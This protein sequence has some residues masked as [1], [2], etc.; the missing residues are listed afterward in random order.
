MGGI[1]LIVL[2]YVMLILFVVLIAVDS[3]YFYILNKAVLNYKDK[4]K[5]KCQ[6]PGYNIYM[7][8]KWKKEFKE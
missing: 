3:V 1:I 6:I 8:L 5:I 2:S 4:N 7:Y